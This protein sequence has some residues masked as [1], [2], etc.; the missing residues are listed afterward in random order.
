MLERGFYEEF[1]KDSLELGVSTE[2]SALKALE[3]YHKKMKRAITLKNK[4]KAS[5]EGENHRT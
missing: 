3:N 1:E 5:G 4:N 2:L